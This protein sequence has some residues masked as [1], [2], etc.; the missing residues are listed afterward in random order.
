MFAACPFGGVAVT[1]PER[2][3]KPWPPLE[4]RPD[5]RE[6]AFAALEDLPQQWIVGYVR[7]EPVRVRHIRRDLEAGTVRPE[8]VITVLLERRMLRPGF[9]CQS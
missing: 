7:L 3:P 2:E 9:G 8:R 6:L 1:A 4:R 5:V